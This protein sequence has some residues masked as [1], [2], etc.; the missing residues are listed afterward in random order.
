MWPKHGFLTSV[1]YWGDQGGQKRG[2]G[3]GGK[4]GGHGCTCY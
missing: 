4:Q 2:G 3:G 1:W